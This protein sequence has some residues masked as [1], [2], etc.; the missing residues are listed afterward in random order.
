MILVLRFLLLAQNTTPVAA[1][2]MILEEHLGLW[3]RPD[4]PVL[5]D[6]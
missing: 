4:L 1:Q 3:G 6:W 5:L 2:V